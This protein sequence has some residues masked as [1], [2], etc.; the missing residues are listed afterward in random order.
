MKPSGEETP[1]TA[2]MT[3]FEKAKTFVNARVKDL[4]NPVVYGGYV[5]ATDGRMLYKAPAEGA[6]DDEK[7]GLALNLEN[8]IVKLDMKVAG[9]GAD[10]FRIVKD[11]VNE[12]EERYRKELAEYLNCKEEERRAIKLEC[13]CCGETVHYIDGELIDL[14]KVREDRKEADFRF[15]V[16]VRGIPFAWRHVRT[17][18]AAMPDGVMRLNRGENGSFVL[19]CETE[20]GNEYALVVQG[21]AEAGEECTELETEN[22]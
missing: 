9:A 20:A 12:I 5:Y 1:K 22:V 21:F 4:A 7:H 3:V 13:P 19:V 6:A 17:V 16:K 8:I 2:D 15:P 11:R 14:A 18:L 10:R